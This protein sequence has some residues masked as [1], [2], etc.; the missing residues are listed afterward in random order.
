MTNQ[1]TLFNDDQGRIDGDLPEGPRKR[2]LF[3]QPVEFDHYEPGNMTRYTLALITVRTN[4]FATGCAL[5]WANAPRWANR[6][7]R[8]PSWGYLTL[9]YFFEKLS[10]S[11]IPANFSRLDMFALMEWLSLNGDYEIQRNP[12]WRHD[13]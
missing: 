5:L 1:T 12:E 11:P 10:E 3:V 6:Y 2:D 8:L 13:E 4:G 7:I 9:D